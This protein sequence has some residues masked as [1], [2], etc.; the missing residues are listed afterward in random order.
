L[1]LAAAAAQ[2]SILAEAKA[3]WVDQ[4]RVMVQHK[5]TVYQH[6]LASA[7]V[8]EVEAMTELPQWGAEVAADR[9]S[10]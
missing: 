2:T 7:V 1:V 3:A 8:V 6:F 5:P 10:S 9:V 4:T